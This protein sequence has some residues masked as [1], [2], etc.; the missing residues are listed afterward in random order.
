M[1]NLMVVSWWRFPFG[2]YAYCVFVFVLQELE[3]PL[4]VLFHQESM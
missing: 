4:R 3:A 2:D 1:V